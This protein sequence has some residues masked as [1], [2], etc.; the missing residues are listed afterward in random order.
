MKIIGIEAIPV[1]VPLKKGMT[2]KT[3]H[4]EHATSPYVIVKVHTDDGIVGLGEAP[5]SGLW[6]GE[7]QLGTLAGT[8]FST[9][10]VTG[11]VSA[12]FSPF[13]VPE[14][15]GCERFELSR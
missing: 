6:S 13:A 8:L 10:C 11:P 12:F 3:A 4:G 1:C 5:I 9:V 15:S 2:A 7:T 14:L